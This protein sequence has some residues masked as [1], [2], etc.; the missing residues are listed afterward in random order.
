MTSSPLPTT[1]IGGPDPCNEPACA[2]ASIPVA[3]PDTTATPTLDNCSPKSYATSRPYRVQVRVP[4]MPTRG[5]ATTSIVPRWNN[6][7]GAAMSSTS[8]A[9]YE[10]ESRVATPTAASQ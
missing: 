8:A 9:G 3:N 6:T 2:A 10:A 1:A 7:A 5:P 4:T